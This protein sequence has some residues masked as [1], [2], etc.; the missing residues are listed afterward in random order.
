MLLSMK[1]K[2]SYLLRLEIF[3]NIA[4]NIKN[5]GIVEKF[6]KEN[7]Y[8]IELAYGTFPDRP[9]DSKA[10]WGNPTRIQKIMSKNAEEISGYYS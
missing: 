9:Y 1:R 10:I 4:E 7:G 3:N 6:I 2:E 8:D 5:S